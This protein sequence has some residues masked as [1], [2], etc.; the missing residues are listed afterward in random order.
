M[1]TKIA[2]LSSLFILILILVPTFVI[3]KKKNKSSKEEYKILFLHHSTGEVIFNAGKSTSIISRKLF[4]NR[5]FVHQWFNDYNSSNNTNYKIEEQ[6]FPKNEPYGWSNYPYDYYNIWV[7]NAGDQP[8]KDEPTLEILT[9]KYNLIVFKHCYPVFDM[10]E[11][12][13]QPDIDSP[14][15]S[16]ENYKLQYLA[17]KQKMHEFPNTKFLIWTGAARVE[18]NTTKEQATRAK[19][20]FDWV[21]NEWDTP[22]DNIFL[23]DFYELETEG[24][25]FLKNE[26]ANDPSNSHPGKSFAQKAAPLFCQRITEVIEQN[27]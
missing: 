7:K 18:S 14:V 23:W 1:K 26:Y 2:I 3:M 24:T 20:F 4:K 19:A 5:S 11:D 13:N 9:K 21:R 17:L 6:Y 27:H 15:K 8:Y 12:S 25:L 10:M 22:N 16:L